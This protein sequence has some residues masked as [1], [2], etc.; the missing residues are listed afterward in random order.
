MLGIIESVLVLFLVLFSSLNVVITV[1]S[2]SLGEPASL[3]SHSLKSLSFVIVD[4]SL[5]LV[6]HSV[7]VF[8]SIVV[9]ASSFCWRYFSFLM[10]FLLFDLFLTDS[11]E[12]VILHVEHGAGNVLQAKSGLSVQLSKH[13]RQTGM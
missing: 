9:E 8:A 11:F 5:V 6:I 3:A 1:P 4:T 13:D 10:H 12:R 7:H 2:D